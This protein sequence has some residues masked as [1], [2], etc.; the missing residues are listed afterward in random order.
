[1]SGNFDDVYAMHSGIAREI[2]VHVAD[3]DTLE[4]WRADRLAAM[5]GELAASQVKLSDTLKE[6]EKARTALGEV[7]GAQLAILRMRVAS[8]DLEKALADLRV[9][10]EAGR[11]T[12]TEG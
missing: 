9:S 10:L 3:I 5:C 1:V 7:A 6:V 2:G 4:P 12:I 11:V 8:L